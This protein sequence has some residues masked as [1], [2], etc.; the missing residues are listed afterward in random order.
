MDIDIQNSLDRHEV[1]RK[2][3]EINEIENKNIRENVV[4]A[5]VNLCPDYFWSVP[6]SSSGNYHPKDHRD[7]RGLWLH[8]KRAFTEYERFAPSFYHQERINKNDLDYGRSA[9]LLHD[10]FKYGWPKQNHTTKN[11]DTLAAEILEENTDLD[12]KIIDCV[13]SHNGPWYKGSDPDTD[14][15]LLHHMADMAASD[16]NNPDIAVLDPSRELKKS[17]PSVNKMSK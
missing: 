12:Q 13:D 11:H 6:A 14:L 3:P 16:V 4:D 9:I 1:L 17:F 10:M 15:E 5:F 2:L 8:T 7:A